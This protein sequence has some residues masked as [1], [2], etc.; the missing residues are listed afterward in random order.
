MNML[1]YLGLHPCDID[2]AESEIIE[3]FKSVGLSDKEYDE[4]YD[5]IKYNMENYEDFSWD[6]PTNALISIMFQEAKHVLEKT[7]KG[8]KISSYVNGYDSH[9][10]V[11][12][13]NSKRKLYNEATKEKDREEIEL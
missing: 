6:N 7:Q 13:V 8:F 11:E 9:F 5:N 2:H 10:N 12:T 4:M 1:D 3:A